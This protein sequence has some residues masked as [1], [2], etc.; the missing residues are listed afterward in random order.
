MPYIPLL[1]TLLAVDFLS[2]VSPGP[3]FV[4]ITETAMRQTR[5]QAAALVLGIVTGSVIWSVAVILGLT[6]LFTIWPWLYGAMKMGGGAYLVYL[7]ARAWQDRGRGPATIGTAPEAAPPVRHSI[8]ASYFRG[9]LTNLMNPK[10]I[11]Y[12]GSVFALFMKPGTPAWVH[13]SAIGI[14]MGDG[15]VWYGTLAALFSSQ[16]AQRLHARAERTIRRVTGTVMMGLG[17]KLM[18]ARD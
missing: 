2:V 8:A 1:L 10:S 14:V 15:L 6:A 17:V 16:I 18:L 11:V 12:F 5:R 3:N 9:L 7:G 13:L 4:V